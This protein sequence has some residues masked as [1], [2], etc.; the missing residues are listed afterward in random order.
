MATPVEGAA[1]APPDM[2]VDKAV[3]AVAAEVVRMMNCPEVDERTGLVKKRVR[4]TA[5]SSRRACICRVAGHA[6]LARI[7]GSSSKGSHASYQSNE[8][9]VKHSRSKPDE[10]CGMVFD[11]RHEVE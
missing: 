4:Y 3:R 5:W 2:V 10:Q 7:N 11:R 1:L 8:R 9:T 6:W